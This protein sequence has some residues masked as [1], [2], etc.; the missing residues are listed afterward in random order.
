VKRS[1]F[2]LLLL[3]TLASGCSVVEFPTQVRG[4]KVTEDQLKDLV[5][6][7]STRNDVTSVL[8]SPTAKGTF[9]DNTWIYISEVT[10][11]RIGRVQGVN[12]QNVVALTF[13]DSGVLT[14][15]KQMSKKDSKSVDVVARA[16]P[17]P[18]S[19]ASFM[20]QLLG[21]V[22]RFSAGAAPST[23]TGG[24]GSNPQP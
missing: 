7:T 2:A 17:S 18:G 8:G 5:P 11:P 10:Q 19:E 1:A 14:S 13:N 9:D 22:G 16:T 23:G 21:N 15:V 12:S 3:A 6:G 4:N 24:S 20:Q